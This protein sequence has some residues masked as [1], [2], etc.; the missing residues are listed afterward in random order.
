MNGLMSDHRPAAFAEVVSSLFSKP[1]LF[2][3]LRAGAAASAGKYSIENMAE[4][5]RAGIK[6]CLGLPES[7]ARVLGLQKA[8]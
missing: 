4:N 6:S 1:E 8:N 7:T 2:N 3:Q 5:F